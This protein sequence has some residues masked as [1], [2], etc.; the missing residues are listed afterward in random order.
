M[1]QLVLNVNGMTCTA[2]ENRIQRALGKLEGVRQARADHR[3]GEVRVVVDPA[4]T[5]T[6]AVRACITDAGYE[7]SP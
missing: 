6:D 3:A 2:C 5:P 4:K 1:E 7:V